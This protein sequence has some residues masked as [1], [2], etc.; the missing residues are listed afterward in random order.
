M[1]KLPCRVFMSY[2]TCSLHVYQ[3]INSCHFTHRF[4]VLFHLCFHCLAQLMSL[5]NVQCIYSLSPGFYHYLCKQY[6]L[7]VIFSPLPQCMVVQK[8]Q[9]T[10]QNHHYHHH[11]H[12]SI[13]VK[14]LQVIRHASKHT[15]NSLNLHT[16]FMGQLLL[17]FLFTYDDTKA[18]KNK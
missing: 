3:R 5:G 2:P 14:Y 11:H 18:Q 15:F 7:T 8:V 10:Y 4:C 16:N 9:G 17:I 12:S 6:I 1:Y 13:F